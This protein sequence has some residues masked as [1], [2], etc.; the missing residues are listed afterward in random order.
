MVPEGFVDE[1]VEGPRSVETG[2][3]QL[4]DIN[5]A[6]NTAYGTQRLMTLF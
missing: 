2:P 4:I 1:G 5:I 3:P 6:I